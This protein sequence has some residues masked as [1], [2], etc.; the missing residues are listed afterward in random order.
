MNKFFDFLQK[1]A[2]EYGT[3]IPLSILV[4]GFL[5]ALLLFQLNLLSPVA[6]GVIFILIGFVLTGGFGMYKR[7]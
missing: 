2:D 3:V 4:L 7:G 6:G 5:V 1:Q